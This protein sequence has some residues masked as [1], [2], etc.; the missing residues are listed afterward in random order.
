LRIRTDA[1]FFFA[2]AQLFPS[3][4]DN[5]A[6]EKL[7]GACQDATAILRTELIPFHEDIPDTANT[8]CWATPVTTRQDDVV[9]IVTNQIATIDKTPDPD[10]ISF[11]TDNFYF[12]A[13]GRFKHDRLV[14]HGLMIT[15]A[16][17]SREPH[18]TSYSWPHPISSGTLNPKTVER[19]RAVILAANQE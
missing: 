11:T 14:S 10:D 7:M 5:S 1:Q 9:H 4:D 16:D 12:Y 2:R 17:G 3:S 18:K 13:D 8:L 15:N 6:K 19:A